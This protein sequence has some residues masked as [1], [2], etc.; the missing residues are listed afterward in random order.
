MRRYYAAIDLIRSPHSKSI[1]Y[2]GSAKAKA[3]AGGWSEHSPPSH[4]M[5][6]VLQVRS[7]LILWN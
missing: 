2:G 3:V 5:Q 4:S 7:T 6:T 1:L